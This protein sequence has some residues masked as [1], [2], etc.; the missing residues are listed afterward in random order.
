MPSPTP[1]LQ[2]EYQ[3]LFDTCSIKPEKNS[4][5][6]TILAKIVK[7]KDLYEAVE[8]RLNIPWYFIG[9]IHCMEGSCNFKVHLH[10]G[11]PLSA[12][13]VQVPPGRPKNG[14]PPFSWEI[15]AEDALIMKKFD[16]ETDW[17]IP[18][19]LFRLEGYNGFGYRKSTINIPSPYLWSYSNHYTKGKFVAD[20]RF[21][22]TAVSKQCGAAVLL[23]RFFEKQIAKDIPDR[24]SLIKELGREVTFAGNRFSAKAAELQRLLN[25]NG[26]FLKV[27]GKAGRN[28]SD[29]YFRVTGEF[30]PND[31][32]A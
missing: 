32:G 31:P 16:S 25:A 3:R 22:A 1:Q 23:R 21:S 9:I 19:M 29:A 5:V 4:E 11:D 2:S 12:R 30:L 10:N 6:D 7:G 14:T 28:T 13:T 26:A 18:A 24:V 17:S 15:S 8:K 27:D 20:G